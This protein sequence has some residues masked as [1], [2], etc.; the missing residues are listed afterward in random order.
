ML[1]LAGCQHAAPLS[2]AAMVDSQAAVAPVTGRIVMDARLLQALVSDIA[3]GATVALIDAEGGQ[4]VATTVSSATGAF[5]LAFQAGFSPV[6][7]HPYVLEA[8]KGL[9]MGGTPNRAGAPA[10]R[11]RTL[12]FFENGGW[13]S[14][15]SATPGSPV[16]IGEDTT[17]LSVI[18]SLRGLSPSDELGL[19]GALSG[20]SFASTGAVSAAEFSYVQ[21]LVQA[22]VADDQDP[23]EAIGYD[24][25]GSTPATQYH[26]QLAPV[27]FG[28]DLNPAVLSPGGSL[29]VSGQ[30]PGT[31]SVTVGGLD[32]ATWSLSPRHD[33]LTAT[34]SSG[35]YSGWLAFSL[36]SATWTGPFVPVH[37]TIGTLAG[38]VAG[39][40]DGT[41]SAAAFNTPE[42]MA[43]GPDGNLYVADA[44]NNRIRMVTPS[45]V[46]TTVAGNG[47]AGHVDGPALSAEFDF[48]EGLA[49]DAAGDLYVADTG[50]NMIREITPGGVVSTVAGQ[51]TAGYQDGVGTSARFQYPRGVATDAAGNLYVAD[52]VNQ[53]IREI[54]PGGVVTTLAGNGTA[55][56]ADGLAS[57]AEFHYPVG[58]AV[59]GSGNVFVADWENF[60]IRKIAGGIVSTVAGDGTSA[61]Q[62]G[63]GTAAEFNSPY[64]MAVDGAGNLYVADIGNGM[65][66]EV[67]PGG[68]VTTVGGNGQIAYLD[69]P[70][71][72]AALYWPIGVTIAG[73]GRIYVT[74][75]IDQ[76]IRV[77]VP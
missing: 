58:I 61:F 70:A 47:T 37:G 56:F 24:A 46:V 26:P 1:G 12:L 28:G 7:G 17:A 15:T 29:I 10:A 35:A 19:V 21:G 2:P 68:Q 32:V 34:L 65:I 42:Q 53:R 62:N 30:F 25:G 4:T 51:P 5:S 66:R 50:N 39:Y 6:A 22:A 20:A 41:G 57:S 73:S 33:Q 48:P 8:Q 44:R 36:G 75:Q 76:R 67:T 43:I 63:T 59:D 52:T 54:A 40:L 16:G 72:S 69:G 74:D 14:P 23:L 60:R 77:L 31:G 71:A 11:L 9:A 64:G 49:F 27:A 13:V 55:A 38:S 18:A 3:D 45:G